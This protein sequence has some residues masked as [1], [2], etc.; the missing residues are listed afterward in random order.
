[1]NS[2]RGN[3]K[4]QQPLHHPAG[5][6]SQSGGD[7]SLQQI[8]SRRKHLTTIP[9]SSR[10]VGR[11]DRIGRL[12]RLPGELLQREHSR[13]HPQLLLRFRSRTEGAVQK[14][15]RRL[16]CCR[17][18]A[19]LNFVLDKS[20]GE[21]GGADFRLNLCCRLDPLNSVAKPRF[22]APFFKSFAT[23]RDKLFL[24]RRDFCQSRDISGCRFRGRAFLGS[25]FVR[26]VRVGRRQ[27]IRPI[28]PQEHRGRD[29]LASDAAGLRVVG[30]LA[31]AFRRHQDRPAGSGDENTLVGFLGGDAPRLQVFDGSPNDAFVGQ[32]DQ[33]RFVE[34]VEQ[35]AEFRTV[36]RGHEFA[37][38]APGHE[39]TKSERS[40]KPPLIMLWSRR[41]ATFI[42]T[43]ND[44]FSL[45]NRTPPS[46]NR[47]LAP[48]G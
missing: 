31:R 7:D 4:R 24:H 21:A 30:C 5:G 41:S 20:H 46:A 47:M 37:S 10:G 3:G 22:P 1:M 29:D 9:W 14:P 26:C 16:S 12:D 18:K 19:T 45:R 17:K 39:A 25:D 11:R 40:Q 6:V 28:V 34:R 23:Y 2:C 48:P 15:G 33:T 13:C 43:S 32:R 44:M 38:G 35:L 36:F 27:R 8:P 42:S